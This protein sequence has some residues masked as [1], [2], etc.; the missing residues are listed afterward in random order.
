MPI[1]ISMRVGEAQPN[2]S[3]L[4]FKAPGG[5][6]VGHLPRV[7]PFTQNLTSGIIRGEGR[8]PVRWSWLEVGRSD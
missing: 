3:M 7:S 4:K 2:I 8:S 1:N 5:T 6:F